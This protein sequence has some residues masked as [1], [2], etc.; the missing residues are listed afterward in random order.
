MFWQHIGVGWAVMN[1]NF[2]RTSEKLRREERNE[3]VKGGRGA[4]RSTKSSETPPRG[5]GV[6][7]HDRR[8]AQGGRGRGLE[9]QRE[10]GRGIGSACPAGSHVC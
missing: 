4:R 6:V 9:K 5:L 3:E 1:F 2:Q 8:R 10:E 7:S